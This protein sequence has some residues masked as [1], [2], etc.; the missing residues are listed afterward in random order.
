VEEFVSDGGFA[1]SIKEYLYRFLG[2]LSTKYI[3]VKVVEIVEVFSDNF[4]V[5]LFTRG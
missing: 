4:I 2:N 3:M 1:N 5:W